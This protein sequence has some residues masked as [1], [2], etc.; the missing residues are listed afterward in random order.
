MLDL[1]EAHTSHIFTT[2]KNPY[3]KL[4]DKSRPIDIN[5]LDDKAK[6]NLT[7]LNY[8]QGLEASRDDCERQ[9]DERL[10][11]KCEQIARRIYV[12]FDRAKDREGSGYLGW[13]Q[14]EERY[15]D[16]Y[17]DWVNE[18]IISLIRGSDAKED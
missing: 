16:V 5:K 4:A 14:R 18:K 3:D 6:V 1:S 8:Q 15:K 9:L 12:H 10:E 13:E 7:W 11:G 2:P 17:R